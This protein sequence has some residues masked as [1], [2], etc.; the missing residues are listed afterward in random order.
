MR[1]AITVAT[2]LVMFAPTA[3]ARKW[4]DSTGQYTVEAEFLD[5]KD[6]KVRLSKENSTIVAVPIER[7]SKA[8]QEWVRRQVK[9]KDAVRQRRIDRAN[10]KV[11]AE[12]TSCHATFQ[13]TRRGEG[14]LQHR[15]PSVTR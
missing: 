10:R 12:V 1:T 14:E 3:F 15:H 7:L 4:T 13:I 6:G 11:A 2:V 8:D 5:F 9:E